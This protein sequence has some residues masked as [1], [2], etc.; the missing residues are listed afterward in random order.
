MKGKQM[1]T[2][3]KQSG[4]IRLLTPLAAV[5]IGGLLLGLTGCSTNRQQTKGTPEESG[6]LGDYSQMQK[7]LAGHA[8]LYYE[9]ANVDWAKYTKVWIQ[10]VELWKSDDPGSPM[11]KISPEN[12]QTLIDLFHTA[13]YN[14]LSTNYTI[15]DHGGPDVLV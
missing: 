9:R 8:D 12:Q 3:M 2:P 11:N 14:S 10:P 4:G 7:G 1:K 5:V 15:V 6:F 13:L